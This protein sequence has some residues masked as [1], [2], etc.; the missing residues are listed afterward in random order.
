MKVIRDG[1]EVTL[2]VKV[3]ELKED[4]LAAT[5][6]SSPKSKLGIDVQ[7]L[8]P[9]LA[10]KFGIK[11]DKGVVITSVEPDSPAEG[12]GLQPGDL[13]LEINRSKVATVNQVRKA[14][15][16]TRPDEPTVLLVKRDG[17]TRY[18]VITSEG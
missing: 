13:I 5:T 7:Q 18:V 17:D 6:P 15:E 12:A 1:A 3:G 8:N 9:A 11:D 16:K 4:Q 10:R 14:L 2:Q